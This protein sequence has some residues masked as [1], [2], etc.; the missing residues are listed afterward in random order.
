MKIGTLIEG[1][2]I[3]TEDYF[4]KYKANLETRL[5]TEISSLQAVINSKGIEI[6]ELLSSRELSFTT[7]LEQGTLDFMKSK[8]EERPQYDKD[9]I[10]NAK[11]EKYTDKQLR[12]TFRLVL[13]KNLSKKEVFRII[14]QFKPIPL[15]FY[16]G[17]V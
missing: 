9:K 13:T 14:N 7:E 5:S 12:Q 15:K 6:Y 10:L 4:N 11:L 16:K 17:I 1:Q 3:I 2:F 8:L